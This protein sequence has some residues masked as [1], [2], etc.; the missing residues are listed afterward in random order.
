MDTK[1]S[2]LK[3]K[4][5]LLSELNQLGYETVNDMA[6]LSVVESLRIPGMGG[7]DW[8]KIAKAQ[9]REPYPRKRRTYSG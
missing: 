5:W 3:L 9:G 8:Q 1:L 2:D 6:H 4:P 7:R